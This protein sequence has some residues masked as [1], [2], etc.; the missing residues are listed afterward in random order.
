VNNQ[1][2]D[3]PLYDFDNTTRFQ[4]LLRNVNPDFL[5]PSAN[6]FQI[7]LNSEGVGLGNSATALEVPLD[8]VGMDRTASPDIGAYQAIMFAEDN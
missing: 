4:N 7:G 6:Q 8:I 1:F 2:G 3:N 5:N